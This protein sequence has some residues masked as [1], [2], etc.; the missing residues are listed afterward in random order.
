MS[1]DNFKTS[2]G[3]FGLMETETTH[4]PSVE[5]IECIYNLSGDFFTGRNYFCDSKRAKRRI[6]RPSPMRKAERN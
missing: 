6:T 3:H 4:L 1:V 2:I 5:L